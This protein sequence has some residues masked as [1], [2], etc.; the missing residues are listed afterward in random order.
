MNK[1]QMIDVFD[2][3][4]EIHIS[5]G[6][7]PLTILDNILHSFKYDQSYIEELMGKARV[8]FRSVQK[9]YAFYIN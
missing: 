6:N 4:I 1:E 2:A 3:V 5:T 8:Y 9:S 7:N